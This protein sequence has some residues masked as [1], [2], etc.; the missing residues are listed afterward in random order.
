MEKKNGLEIFFFY[1]AVYS[2]VAVSTVNF[3]DKSPREIV[4]DVAMRYVYGFCTGV[5]SALG[6]MLSV[7]AFNYFK[8][9]KKK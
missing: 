6:W 5:S 1:L 4:I 8:K 9:N 7:E 2:I 3:D